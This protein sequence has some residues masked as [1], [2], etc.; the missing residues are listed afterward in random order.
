MALLSSAQAAAVRAVRALAWKDAFVLEQAAVSTD[1]EDLYDD[2]A[3]DAPTP[4]TLYGDWQWVETQ[5]AE[6]TPGGAAI[7]GHVALST[8][9]EH[10]D[11]LNAAGARIIV[12]NI[13]CQILSVSQYPVNG[14]CVVRAARLTSEEVEA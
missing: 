13:R 1:I 6:G 7:Q 14:E 12:D 3:A 5:E 2:A 8:S 10:W 9:V 11:L 4:T